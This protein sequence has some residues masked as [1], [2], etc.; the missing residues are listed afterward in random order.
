ME[1]GVRLTPVAQREQGI[2]GLQGYVRC[3]RSSLIW[4]FMLY[5]PFLTL[6]EPSGKSIQSAQICPDHVHPTL[7]HLAPCQ[8]PRKCYAQ[9][10][11][12]CLHGQEALI[13]KGGCFHPIWKGKGPMDLCSSFRSILVSSHIGKCL[14]RSI[15]QRQGYSLSERYLQK[16]QIGG[17][18]AVPVTLGVHTLRAPT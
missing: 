5:L 18:R 4:T 13:R 16:E 17:R 11:K 10:L 1:G 14:H 12:L 8:L 9:L 7:C 6:N 15:R 3:R 2:T